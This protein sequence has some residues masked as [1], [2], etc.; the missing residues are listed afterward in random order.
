MSHNKTARPDKQRAAPE[1]GELG[2]DK[3]SKAF[4]EGREAAREAFKTLR[5]VLKKGKE[6]NS[7]S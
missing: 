2:Q 3:E 5:Q 4:A 6:G 7:A 1:A